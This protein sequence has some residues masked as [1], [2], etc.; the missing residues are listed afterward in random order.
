[1][2]VLVLLAGIKTAIDDG[3][4][5]INESF[6]KPE[7]EQTGSTVERI[8]N[9]DKKPETE[10]PAEKE[11]EK[12][13]KGKGK[14]KAETKPEPEKEAETTKP[15]EETKPEPEAEVLPAKWKC[16]RCGRLLKDN[17][18][19]VKGDLCAHCKGT[20]AELEK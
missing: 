16:L 8:L 2:D 14:K 20:I 15:P 9:K 6:P 1:M 4:C 10:K 19:D 5:T 17:G 7:A 11:P 3:D 18:E 13:K 12:P